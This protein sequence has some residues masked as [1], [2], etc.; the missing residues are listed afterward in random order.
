MFV[1]RHNSVTDPQL[2]ERLWRLY[3][4]AFRPISELAVCREMM[5]R[6]EFEQLV[7]DPVNRTWV[8]W[9]DDAPVAM[10]VITTDINTT[11]YLSKQFFE[12][13][14]PDHVLRNAVHYVLFVVVHPVY[15]AKGAL[16]KL[17][18]ESF[19]LEADEGNLVV[20]DTPLVNQPSE[21]GGMAELVGRLAQMVSPGVEARQVD[22]QRFYAID[23]EQG[24]RHRRA[25]ADQVGET[26][27]ETSR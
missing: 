4:L 26:A 16:V 17:S 22:V 23:F 20:F 7:A 3:E 25:L 14:Y 9:H 12:R 13:T 8:L 15:E 11:Q 19:G 18:R 5:H 1:T 6:H 2:R 10:T 21:R 27:V 24:A